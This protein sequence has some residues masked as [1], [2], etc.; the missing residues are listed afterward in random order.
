[1]LSTIVFNGSVGQSILFCFGMVECGSRSLYMLEIRN[2]SLFLQFYYRFLVTLSSVGLTFSISYKL[3][4]QKFCLYLCVNH[5][6]MLSHQID[7]REVSISSSPN[8]YRYLLLVSKAL[9]QMFFLWAILFRMQTLVAN[10]L[11]QP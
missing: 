7:G 4:S 6:G 9:S 8:S 2:V 11:L 5:S 1:M 10:A 3:L